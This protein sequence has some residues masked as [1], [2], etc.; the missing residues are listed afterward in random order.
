[1]KIPTRHEAE[2]MIAEA[3][4]RNPGPWVSHSRY[5][6][7]AAQAIASQHPELDPEAAFIP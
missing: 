7:E 4:R 2:E 5:T 1:M 6:G 3:E